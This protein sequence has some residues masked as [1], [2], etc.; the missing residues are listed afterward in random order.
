MSDARINQ[1]TNNFLEEHKKAPE[2]FYAHDLVFEPRGPDS[3][4]VSSLRE[5]TQL[6]KIK[7]ISL[8]ATFPIKLKSLESCCGLLA[9]YSGYIFSNVDR[10]IPHARKEKNPERHTSLRQIAKSLNLTTVG[11]IFDVDSFSY[12]SEYIGIKNCKAYFAS[13]TL[14]AYQ[15]ELC[16]LIDKKNTVI[17][18]CDIDAGFG[19]PI[20]DEGRSPHWVLAFGYVEIRGKISFLVSHYNRYCLF[21]ANTL[22]DS[23][24]QLPEIFPKPYR[25]KSK[26]LGRTAKI[27]FVEKAPD[28]PPQCVKELKNQSLSKFRFTF[29]AIPHSHD[30]LH[31]I[32]EKPSSKLNFN[33]KNLCSRLR[34]K[35]KF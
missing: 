27:E 26:E 29:F 6:E 32:Q 2:D 19:F 28:S 30:M 15:Q 31:A 20:K 4:G 18:S 10:M 13:K 11:E 14:A 12:L 9:A 33:M 8:P 25:I 7:K 17:V 22:F 16:D 5:L 3:I 35:F 23:N 24:M 1:Q 34:K 21:T